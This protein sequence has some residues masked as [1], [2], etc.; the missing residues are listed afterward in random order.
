MKRSGLASLNIQLELS[1]Y[2][3]LV[4]EVTSHKTHT[5]LCTHKARMALFHRPGNP[6]PALDSFLSR[7]P[8]L[9][10]LLGELCEECH[11]VPPTVL[12]YLTGID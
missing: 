6:V 1:Y 11:R 5:P 3:P 4:N 12:V 10:G 2:L 7:Q 9:V 8:L